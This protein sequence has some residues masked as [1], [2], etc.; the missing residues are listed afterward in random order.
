[1]ERGALG[2]YAERAGVGGCPENPEWH[3]EG[4]VFV[5]TGHVL[6]HFARERVGDPSDWTVGLALLC[7]DLG[8]PATT[9]RGEDGV[10][11]SI[12]HSEAGE[13]PA[14]PPPAPL[15]PRAGPRAT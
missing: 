1:E 11:R 8:K 2:F 14:P 10:I 4:D 6:D 9:A 5:H 3:P 12:G 13:A 15:T 7:H